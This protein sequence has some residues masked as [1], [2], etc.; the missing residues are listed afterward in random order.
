MNAQV[1]ALDVGIQ[2]RRDCIPLIFPPAGENV[3]E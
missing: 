3:I 1:F 2:A